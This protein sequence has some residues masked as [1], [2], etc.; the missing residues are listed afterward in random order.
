[1]YYVKK[2]IYI[3]IYIWSSFKTPTEEFWR[4]LLSLW[5]R[6]KV[7]LLECVKNTASRKVTGSKPRGIRKASRKV[8]L[9]LITTWL[10]PPS[11]RHPGFP[12]NTNVY[13][14][15]KR[16]VSGSHI[17][18]KLSIWS[19]GVQMATYLSVYPTAYPYRLPSTLITFCKK[20]RFPEGIRKQKAVFPE[21]IPEAY[22]QQQCD[23]RVLNILHIYKI[24]IYTVIYIYFFFK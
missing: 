14:E 3:Y 12:K 19:Q 23:K 13:P 16:K 2:Q 17:G 9:I 18:G 10:I 7:Q 15:A 11:G 20:H 22:S 24:Y 5:D 21:G 1:M 8:F 4:T 6:Q